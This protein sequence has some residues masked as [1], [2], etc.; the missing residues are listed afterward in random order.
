MPGAIA[1]TVG[2]VLFPIVLLMGGGLV[3]ALLGNSLQRDGERRA[4]GS[5][6][7]SLDD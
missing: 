4:V 7:A 3:A 2:L 6:L 5:E 1:I